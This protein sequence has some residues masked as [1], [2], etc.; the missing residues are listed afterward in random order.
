MVI[1]AIVRELEAVMVPEAAT[2]IADNIATKTTR[3]LSM[4]NRKMRLG[5]IP[6]SKK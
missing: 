3:A 5:Q 6:W 4:F 2:V 1:D